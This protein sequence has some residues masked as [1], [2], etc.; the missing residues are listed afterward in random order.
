[1]P[2][3]LK[4]R[5]KKIVAI[6]TGFTAINLVAEYN[7]Y[8]SAPYAISKAALNMLVAEFSAQYANDGVL[9]MAVCPGVVD[10]GY[11]TDREHSFIHVS[12]CTTRD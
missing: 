4:G 6:S 11:T 12:S 9:I 10:T 3:I 7:V 8:N 1:M 2:L 5:A